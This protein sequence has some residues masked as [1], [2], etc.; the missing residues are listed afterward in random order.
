MGRVTHNVAEKHDDNTTPVMADQLLREFFPDEYG[1][2]GSPETAE[3]ADEPASTG[4]TSFGSW[5]V[6]STAELT[7]ASQVENPRPGGDSG[8]GS[9]GGSGD[10]SS[11]LPMLIGLGALLVSVGIISALFVGRGVSVAGDVTAGGDADPAGP[12][13]DGVPTSDAVDT[14]SDATEQVD[15]DVAAELAGDSVPA[16]VVA[17]NVRADAVEGARSASGLAELRLDPQNN[18]VCY[19]FEVVGIDEPFEAR[20][21][22]GRSG[23][24]GG[25]V[26]DFGSLD[27]SSIG[28]APVPASDL[29]V[30][31]SDPINH[32]IE[33]NDEQ[34]EVVVQAQ[35]SD[36][37]DPTRSADTDT[38]AVDPDA[39][40]LIISAGQMTYRGQVADEET[41]DRLMSEL[42]GGH[43]PTG[44]AVVDELEVLPGAPPPSGDIV[45]DESLLFAVDSDVLADGEKVLED[46]AEL[47]IAHPDWT[48]VIVGHTDSTGSVAHNQELSLRRANAVRRSLVEFG[49]PASGLATLGAGDTQPIGDNTTDDGRAQN[50]RIE[51]RIERGG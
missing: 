28:C 16:G 45:V 7:E 6:T 20:I 43:H 27:N 49:V 4:E 48:M 38:V 47:F 23:A 2:E 10:N 51:F 42:E 25:V 11:R 40:V 37:V 36:A 1:A 12:V 31:L 13:T 18:E 35:L 17:F 24:D 30:L 22:G 5:Q 15:A 3:G 9:D 14:T 46:L 50:R 44:I 21:S 39:A 19:S 26:V 8:S 32:Y 34:R 29:A 33:L 41:A